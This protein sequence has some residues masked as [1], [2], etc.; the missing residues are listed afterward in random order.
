MVENHFAEIVFQGIAIDGVAAIHRFAGHYPESAEHGAGANGNA[1][2][3][4]TPGIIS[5]A[6]PILQRI[7]T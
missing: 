7:F 5:P 4:A 6:L 2:Q 1:S 3:A